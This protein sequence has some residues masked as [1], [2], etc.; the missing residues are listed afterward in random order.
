[1]LG[2]GGI[3]GGGAD[4][5]A[6]VGTL[7]DRAREAGHVDQCRRPLEG[8]AHQVDEVRAAAEVLGS[9]LRAE[10]DRLGRI[11]GARI[12]EGRHAGASAPWASAIAATMPL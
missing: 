8:L 12:G 7:L 9:G 10:A 5:E 11:G 2:D 1:M 3:F 4:Q 6:A